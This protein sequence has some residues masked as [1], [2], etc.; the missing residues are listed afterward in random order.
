MHV[1]YIYIY[2]YMHV[3]ISTYM[4]VDMDFYISCQGYVTRVLE[5]QRKSSRVICPMADT[6]RLGQAG[7]REDAPLRPGSR[8]LATRFLGWNLLVSLNHE[9]GPRLRQ[10][11][12]PYGKLA[13][14]ERLTGKP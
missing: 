1:V 3:K 11:S 2:I 5:V 13:I 14:L 6:Q 8:R 12:A 7:V 4:Y 10:R 9:K